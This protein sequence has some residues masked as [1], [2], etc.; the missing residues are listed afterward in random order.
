MAGGL[1]VSSGISAGAPQPSRL[2]KHYSDLP[3]ALQAGYVIT[4]S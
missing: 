3:Q 4:R 2:A 1:W